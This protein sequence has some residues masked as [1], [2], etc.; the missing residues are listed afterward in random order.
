MDI[1]DLSVDLVEGHNTF[2]G[3]GQH[4]GVSSFAFFTKGYIKTFC[5]GYTWLCYR[6]SEC[7]VSFHVVTSQHP[8]SQ[9]SVFLH[10]IDRAE[11]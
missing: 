2:W 6:R 5:L 10:L 11:L 7:L 8:V 4:R 1:S 9:K 3:Y